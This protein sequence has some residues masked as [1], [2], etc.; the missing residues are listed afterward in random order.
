M[1][2]DPPTIHPLLI[3]MGTKGAGMPLTGSAVPGVAWRKAR[4]SVSNG[5]CVEVAP[6]NG[7]IAVRDSKNPEGPILEYTTDA[8]STFLDGARQGRFDHPRRA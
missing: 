4:R 3:N 2:L 1:T 8:W 5:A 7:M 6:I